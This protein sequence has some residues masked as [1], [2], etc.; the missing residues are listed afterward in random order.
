MSAKNKLEAMK[1]LPVPER[2]EA[3][4]RGPDGSILCIEAETR[5]EL[6]DEIETQKAHPPAMIL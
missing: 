6:F 1:K 4:I 2:W 3:T 5:E